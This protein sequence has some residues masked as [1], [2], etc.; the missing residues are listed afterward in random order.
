MQPPAKYYRKKI[1]KMQ[2]KIDTLQGLSTELVELQYE[3]NR[4]SRNIAEGTLRQIKD[5]DRV[6]SLIK[7]RLL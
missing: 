3:S 1:A 2:G 4:Y 5:I 7:K 6:M